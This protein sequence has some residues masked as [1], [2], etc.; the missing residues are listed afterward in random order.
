MP[1]IGGPDS[2]SDKPKERATGHLSCHRGDWDAFAMHDPGSRPRA[3]PQPDRAILAGTCVN[4]YRNKTVSA[5]GPK[6][7]RQHLHNC[8]CRRPRYRLQA[9]LQ[10]APAGPCPARTIA[11]DYRYTGA[12]G[13]LWKRRKPD[14]RIIGVHGGNSDISEGPTRSEGGLK[15]GN[16][17]LPHS[18]GEAGVNDKVQVRFSFLARHEPPGVQRFQCPD[19]RIHIWD[20]GDWLRLNGQDKACRC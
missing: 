10:Y 3:C 6:P 14:V 12:C 7:L 20:R 8:Q 9:R 2:R 15:R 18:H 19:Y 13:L 17:L 16:G 4:L 11:E 1:A 5:T